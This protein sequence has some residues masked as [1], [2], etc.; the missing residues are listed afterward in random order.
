MGW[1]QT[2]HAVMQIP[3]I[4]ANVYFSLP[5]YIHCPS[6]F[7]ILLWITIPGKLVA[8]AEAQ[9]PSLEVFVKLPWSSG[10]YF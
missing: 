5:E 7:Q 2:G 4:I 1:L 6:G 10:F 9:V 3:E 8:N